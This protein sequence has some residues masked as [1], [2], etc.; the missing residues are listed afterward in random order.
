MASR[1]TLVV[2]PPAA[3]RGAGLL[4]V[5]PKAAGPS[6]GPAATS[7]TIRGPAAAAM[8]QNMQ[9]QAG[10]T[11]TGKAA[12]AQLTAM[13]QQAAKQQPPPKKTGRPAIAA[14]TPV[15]SAARRRA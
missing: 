7:S 9:R 4:N 15:R 14:A 5:P 12:A 3:K 2:A 8:L 1:K 13:Q 11:V 6:K 10:K